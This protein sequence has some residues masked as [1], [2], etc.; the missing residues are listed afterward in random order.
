MS[1]A[2]Y[3]RRKRS[4]GE[5][6]RRPGGGRLR[7]EE[8]E[9][10]V[11]PVLKGTVALVTGASSGIGAAAAAALAAHGAAVALAARRGDRLEALAADIR[12]PG[13]TALVLESEITGE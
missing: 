13:G 8:G 12:G 3:A 2:S 6:Q 10:E 4:P 5:D 9:V 7:A 1:S 11:Q